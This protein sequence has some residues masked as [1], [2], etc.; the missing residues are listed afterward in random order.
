MNQEQRTFVAYTGIANPDA[1]YVRERLRKAKTYAD[2]GIRDSS[3]N[4]WLQVLQDLC[5]GGPSWPMQTK[6]PVAR[7]FI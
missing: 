4:A 6:R 1:P 5:A 2:D 3:S 7:E